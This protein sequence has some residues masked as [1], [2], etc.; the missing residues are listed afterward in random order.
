V[1][2]LLL[3]ERATTRIYSSGF[4]AL[5]PKINHFLRAKAFGR[6]VRF[7]KGSSKRMKD[8]FCINGIFLPLSYFNKLKV[9][10][11]SERR[12]SCNRE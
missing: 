9:K 8:K 7:F 3:V 6:D 11:W 12:A 5:A 4:A 2:R 1:F 10:E